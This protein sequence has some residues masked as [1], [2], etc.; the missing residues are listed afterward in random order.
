MR[1]IRFSTQRGYWNR[2]LGN[3]DT[4]VLDEQDCLVPVYAGIATMPAQVKRTGAE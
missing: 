1:V 2:L 3:M 4:V